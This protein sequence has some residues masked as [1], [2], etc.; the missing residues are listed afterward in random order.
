MTPERAK[1]L[2]SIEEVGRRRVPVPPL[3]VELLGN[4]LVT[5]YFLTQVIFWQGV[6]EDED[7]PRQWWWK[8]REEW[9]EELGLGRYQQ[10][11]ARQKLIS[12]DLLEE[13]RRHAERW[14]QTV[15]FRLD[16]AR[17]EEW[18]SRKSNN[19]RDADFQHLEMLTSNISRC[20][21]PTSRGADSQHLISREDLG[22]DPQEISSETRAASSLLVGSAVAEPPRPS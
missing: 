5:A 1:Y 19:D 15:H 18:V 13:Q 9:T 21:S 2:A 17:L 16:W 10:D 7:P 11:R 6:V 8:S 20:Q 3:F 22:D 4:D 12:L 14:D